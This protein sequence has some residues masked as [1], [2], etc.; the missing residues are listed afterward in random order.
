[1][2]IKAVLR[3]G[4]IQPLEPLPPA[5][6]E[7]QE[8]VVEEPAGV[9]NALTI[10]EWEQELEATSSQVPSAEHD[11]FRQALEAIEHESKESVRREWE[12]R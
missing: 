9:E 11:R 2:T 6:M 4:R 10:R 8:L 1:M 7:G 3:D 5:W 12:K